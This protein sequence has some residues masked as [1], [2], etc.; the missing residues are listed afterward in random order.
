MAEKY[1]QKPEEFKK[2]LQN[3]DIEYIKDTI[4]RRKTIELMKQ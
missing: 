3:D 2:H 4:I 1:N